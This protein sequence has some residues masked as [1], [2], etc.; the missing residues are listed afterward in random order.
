MKLFLALALTLILG[1]TAMATPA[2]KPGK[3]AVP[4]VPTLPALPVEPLP[5][6][7]PPTPTVAAPPSAADDVTLYNGQTA[8]DAGL[9]LATW[10]AGSATESTTLSL[11]GGHSLLVTTL[12][13]YQGGVVT[14]VKPADFNT[15]DPDK[16]RTLLLVLRPAPVTRLYQTPAPAPAPTGPPPPNN[17]GPGGSALLPNT[18]TPAVRFASWGGGQMAPARFAQYSGG[19]SSL[20]A[21]HSLHLIFTF[22]GGRQVDM[23]RPFPLPASGD[24][25]EWV[26]VGVPLAALHL[27]D[28][29]A[30]LQSLMIAGDDYGAFYV[31][32]IKLVRDTA[33]ITCFAGDE[34]RVSADEIV[35]LRA[36]ASGGLSTLQY[37]W[38]FDAS[39][40][41]TAQA[42]GQTVTTFYP[43]GGK[44]YKVTLTVSD[45]DG[46]K[47]PAIS[48]TLVHV[49]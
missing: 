47:K 33:P 35:T 19:V 3:S 7:P 5:L 20:S 46:L 39:D 38:N 45:R 23:V 10:G 36:T 32:Q 21:L 8:A 2:H 13:P 34:Q 9:S 6:A 42:E 1:S 48:T 24:S 37:T 22:V 31:G 40:G 18:T 12:D 26:S 49:R 41:I 27:P 16:T 4:S 43:I 28:G 11:A 30:L 17:D 25:D 14:F 29:P 15:P 44:D